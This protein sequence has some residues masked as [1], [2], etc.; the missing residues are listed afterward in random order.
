MNEGDL[1]FM[2]NFWLVCLTN[3]GRF[4]L[5]GWDIDSGSTR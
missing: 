5:M 3:Y 4:F 2:R 1:L